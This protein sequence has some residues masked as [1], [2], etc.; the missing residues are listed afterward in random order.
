MFFNLHENAYTIAV[1]LILVSQRAEVQLVM[2]FGTETMKQN[3]I[4]Q[5]RRQRGNGPTPLEYLIVLYVIG[6]VWEETQEILNEGIRSYLRNMWN[7]IDFSRNS[8]Y[9]FVALLR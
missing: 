3:M 9:C 5:L 6:F 4:E 7:F 8:L 2:M 1:I